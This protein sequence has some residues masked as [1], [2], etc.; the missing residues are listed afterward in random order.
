MA[1]RKKPTNKA[2]ES[3][4]ARS[5]WIEQ[6]ADAF[7]RFYEDHAYAVYNLSLR[8]TCE[9]ESA[10]IASTR[11]F[12]STG[13]DLDREAVI[14]TAV[15]CALAQARKKPQ[16]PEPI[17]DA[18]GELL[19]ALA[20]LAP[21]ERA[22]IALAS[23]EGLKS[24]ALG[25]M[26]G[27]DTKQARD[28]LARSRR[29]TAKRLELTAKQLT[30]RLASLPLVEPPSDMWGGLYA[31]FYAALQSAEA[32]PKETAKRRGMRD[33]AKAP[34]DRGR[35]LVAGALGGIRLPAPVHRMLTEHR[36]LVMVVAAVALAVPATALALLAAT[37]DSTE[38]VVTPIATANATDT[39]GGSGYDSL[40]PKQLDALRKRELRRVANLGNRK[41]RS[42]RKAT[43]KTPARNGGD[44]DTQNP[45]KGNTRPSEPIKET[46]QNPSPKPPAKPKPNPK[47]K[48]PPKDP[49]PDPGSGCLYN[50]DTGT[51][52][53]PQQ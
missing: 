47:P 31:R 30:A 33:S 18:S 36:A 52:I 19:D 11:A 5:S 50:E 9:E 1:K 17:E 10:S 49:D 23:I 6:R 16:V 27:I 29:G 45:G 14:A 4:S 32:A 48:P 40:S 44:A 28:L 43:G 38:P 13:V 42:E 20:G 39:R 25:L 34:R 53:C 21:P 46:G 37:G 35:A 3:E 12:L 15:S 41:G 8:I 22:A 24:Q 26:L 7:A 2:S 51:Y